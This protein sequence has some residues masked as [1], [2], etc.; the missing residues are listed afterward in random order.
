MSDQ[1][2]TLLAIYSNQVS[3]APAIKTAY[4]STVFIR[5]EAKQAKDS[6]RSR[7]TPLPALH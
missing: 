4:V 5:E 1:K 3:I 6:H 2:N 7:E